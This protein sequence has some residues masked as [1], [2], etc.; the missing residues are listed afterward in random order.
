MKF[1]HQWQ[2]FFDKAAGDLLQAFMQNYQKSFEAD[3][4]A[5]QEMQKDSEWQ[6]AKARCEDLRDALQMAE[7]LELLKPFSSQLTNLIL[8]PAGSCCACNFW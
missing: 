5:M 6:R 3:C 1:H 4:K 2:I 7:K 8:G